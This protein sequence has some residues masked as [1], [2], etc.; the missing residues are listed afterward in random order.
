MR[1]ILVAMTLWCTYAYDGVW[2][3][4]RDLYGTPEYIVRQ[5]EWPAIV[6][7]LCDSKDRNTTIY[8]GISGYTIGMQELPAESR[9]TQ[10][11]TP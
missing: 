6:H 11:T 3:D 10:E 4:I 2:P 5:A 8:H 7:A 9:P 1:P